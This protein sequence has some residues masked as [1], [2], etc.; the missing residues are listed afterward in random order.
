M[1]NFFLEKSD[2][3]TKIAMIHA[4]DTKLYLDDYHLFCDKSL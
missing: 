4:V 2:T 1:I 3:Q